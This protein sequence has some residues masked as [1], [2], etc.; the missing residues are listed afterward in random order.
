MNG[1]AVRVRSGAMEPVA[2][3]DLVHVF[4]AAAFVSSLHMFLIET[5]AEFLLELLFESLY[6]ALERFYSFLDRRSHDRRRLAVVDLHSP[7]E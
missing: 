6:F 7:A 3:T 4:H 1:P 5:L 2:S